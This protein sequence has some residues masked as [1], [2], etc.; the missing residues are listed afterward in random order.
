MLSPDLPG[1]FSPYDPWGAAVLTPEQELRLLKEEAGQI[2]EE[3]DGIEK[4]IRE[5]EEARKQ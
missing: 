1:F 4:R 3:L 5:L 2:K